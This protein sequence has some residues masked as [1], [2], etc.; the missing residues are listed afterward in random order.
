MVEDTDDERPT[1]FEQ[2][3]QFAANLAVALAVLFMLILLIRSW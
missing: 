1:K 3:M 2:R